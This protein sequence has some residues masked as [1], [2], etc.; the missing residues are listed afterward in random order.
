[1]TK[2]LATTVALVKW[3]S[4]TGVPNVLSGLK[5]IFKATMVDDAG[6][7]FIYGINLDWLGQ[8]IVDT[9]F[10]NQIGDLDF[11]AE[12]KTADP[13]ATCDF[14][15]GPGFKWGYCLLLNSS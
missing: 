14:A 8:V 10:T 9:A 6:S 13:T 11:P 2:M 3:E 4:V 12:L 7:R 1:M 15:A 5:A